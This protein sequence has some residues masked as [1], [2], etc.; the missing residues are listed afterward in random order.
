MAEQIEFRPYCRDDNHNLSKLIN[1]IFSV[2]RDDRY[3]WWKYVENPA[4]IALSPIAH[5]NGRI[6][7]QIGI[8]PVRFCA[9]DLELIGAQEVDFVIE[10]E[11]RTL[12]IS[13]QLS[14]LR[15]LIY[16]KENI[17]FCYGFTTPITSVIAQKALN[18]VSVGP[19]PRLA[20]V[21]DVR[22]FLQKKIPSKAIASLL[23]TITNTGL[24]SIY[25]VKDKLPEGTCVRYV[26]HFD[27]RFDAFWNS[28]K[29]DYA[30]MTVRDSSYLNWRYVLPPD[31]DYQILSLENTADGEVLGF[32]VLGTKFR[33]V[34]TGYIVDLV[35]PRESAGAV[36]RILLARAIHE[37]H[38]QNMAM[39]VC[40]MFSHCHD[41][42]ELARLGFRY[43][44]ETGR[45]F[46]V[47]I[48]QSKSP[49]FLSKLLTQKRSWY[50]AIG[51]SDFS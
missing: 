32:V 46:V 3:C 10:K 34:P 5:Y 19:I 16:A 51:D 17:A 20:K 49:A 38:Q 15:R 11:H 9:G 1:T 22:P 12:N 24:Q 29:N 6:I 41:F 2:D 4:G 13:Y 18:F 8:I 25:R 43:R 26:N 28:I 48:F 42:A 47:E 31:V 50:I 39:I 44:R 21:L 30:I 37:F 45:D 40:W 36:A 7:G 35:T 27:N 33:H 14:K 23:S